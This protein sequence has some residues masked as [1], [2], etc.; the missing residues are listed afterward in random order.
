M[1]LDGTKHGTKDGTKDLDF[2]PSLGLMVQK[3]ISFVPSGRGLYGKAEKPEETKKPR[4][5]GLSC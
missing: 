1:V 3:D 2:V 5:S 4:I